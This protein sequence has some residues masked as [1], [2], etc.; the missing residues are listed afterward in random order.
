MEN[1]IVSKEIFGKRFSELLES[2][3][4]TTYTIGEKLS[5]NPGTISR[6]ANGLMAPKIP[7]LYMLANLF[8]VN[9]SWLMGYD[10]PKYEDRVEP[11]DPSPPLPSNIMPLPKMYRVP[12]VGTIACGQPILAVENADETVAVPDW[13]NADFALRCKG[14]SMINARIFDGDIVYIKKQ[15]EVESGQIAAVRIQDEATLKRVRLYGDHISLE[16]ENPMYKPI[17]LWEEDMNSVE[18]LG[19]AVGFTSMFM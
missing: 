5:L 10:A 15:P 4:E 2:S 19:L 3:A 8:R 11:D 18:I 12:L 13:I 17:V 16:P 14:D 1:Q 6:Y 7:T 9:P